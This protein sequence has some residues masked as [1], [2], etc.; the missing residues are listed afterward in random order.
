MKR[1]RNFFSAHLAQKRLAGGALV[2]AITQFA[3]SLAGFFRDQAF[4]ITFPLE[5]DPIGIA[6]IYIASFRLS[7]L[8]FQMFVMSSLSVVLVPFLAY[9]LA[10]EREDEMNKITTSLFVLFGIVFGCV[11]LLLAI[12]FPIIAPLLVQ[13]EGEALNLYVSFGRMALFT[14]FLFVFGNTLGQYLIARQRYWIYG[15]TP[16]LW[17]AG[18]IFGIYVLTPHLGVMGPMTGTILGTVLY[19]AIRL[20]GAMWAGLRFHLPKGGIIH[21]EL[22]EMGWLVLPRMAALGLLQLQLLLFDTIGSGLGTEAV[23]V[24]AFAR[25]FQSVVVG[26]AGI[27]L[28]QSAFSLLS[29][30]AA[31]REYHRFAS[32]VKKG[33]LFNILLT[34]PA[35]LGLAALSFI[36]AWM[37][38]LEGPVRSAFI[39][40]LALYCI[41]IPFES[42]NHLLLR[43]FSSL[44]DTLTPAFGT[45]VAL[46]T[47][48]GA[49]YALS[50]TYGL[51]ALPVG[52]AVGQIAQLLL[53]AALLPFTLARKASRD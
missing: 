49:A 1:L 50:Q 35:A 22:K 24:N 15:I 38:H 45:M 30:S 34:V 53:L 42:I 51:A 21:P 14:N 2:L 16:V 19:L 26:V 8:L 41:S 10:S 20:G 36:P 27:A 31:K 5:Q 9:H 6:S 7:D 32:Y 39:L 12:F 28:A 43:A 29:Q 37:L 13:Y 52:F 48:I 25:N 33:V 44:K 23:A 47:G 4:S 17:A 3:A 40:S 11:A 46:M 18:T